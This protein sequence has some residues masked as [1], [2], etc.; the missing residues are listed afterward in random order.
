MALTRDYDTLTTAYKNL[1]EK[2]EDSRVAAD[3]ERRQIG[4]QFRVL[5]PARVPARPVGPIRLKVNGIGLGL[6]LFLGLL[7]VAVL[8]VRDRTF[9]S[10]TD[11]TDVLSL[12]VLALVP[13]VETARD[14]AVQVRRRRL[15]STAV[16]ATVLCAGVV[17]W[18]LQLWKHVM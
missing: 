8:E 6:G 16:A 4:E 14:R 7:V 5:E 2:S 15:L 10:E 13:L 18:R 3:L 1:L 12:P 9:R 11:I 17:F